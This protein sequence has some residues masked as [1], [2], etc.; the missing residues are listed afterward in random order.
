MSE[1][2]PR[3]PANARIEAGA[4]VERNIK[5]EKGLVTYLLVFNITLRRELD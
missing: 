1:V 3:M 4:K 5:R 2:S